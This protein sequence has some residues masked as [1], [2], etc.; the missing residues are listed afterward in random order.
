MAT[1][2]ENMFE[3]VKMIDATR[4]LDNRRLGFSQMRLLPKGK[5]LRPIMNL[6]RRAPGKSSSKVLGPSINTILS[7]VHTFLKLEKASDK[8]QNASLI[9][10]DRAIGCKSLK[11][12][13]DNV[14]GK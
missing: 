13:G 5:D 1:I 2:K 11:A 8:A 3:E 9:A 14:F 4:I 6:R 12:G 7:P 10:S